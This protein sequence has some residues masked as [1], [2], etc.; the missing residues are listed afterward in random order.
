MTK[1]VEGVGSWE[2]EAEENEG[3]KADKKNTDVQYPMPNAPYP[4]SIKIFAV[5][6][7][8]K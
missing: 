5:Y 6:V 3:D 1:N 4:F 7:D 8:A 2:W